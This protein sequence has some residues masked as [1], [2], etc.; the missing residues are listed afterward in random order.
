MRDELPESAS[1]DVDALTEADR[2]ELCILGNK[3]MDGDGEALKAFEEKGAIARCFLA[4]QY[5]D[6]GRVVRDKL[7]R[8]FVGEDD[9]YRRGIELATEELVKELSGNA[10]SPLEQL[11]VEQVVNCWVESSMVDQRAVDR[12]HQGE[13]TATQLEFYHRWQGRAQRRFLAARKALAQTRKLLGINVQ[14]NIAEKQINMQG[15]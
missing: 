9:I 4:D 14:I 3:A 13:L 6:L 7:L 12:L 10:P 15:R 5:G 1:D 2:Q 11:L 8:T